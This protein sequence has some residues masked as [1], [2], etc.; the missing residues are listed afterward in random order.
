MG[1][2]TMTAE[3]GISAETKANF[4][5]LPGIWL[6][7]SEQPK[8]RKG[9]S[10]EV[11]QK[12]CQDS[13]EDVINIL[14]EEDGEV[15]EKM[16]NAEAVINM[17]TE[18]TKAQVKWVLPSEKTDELTDEVWVT[19]QLINNEQETKTY[20]KPTG[21]MWTLGNWKKI[22]LHANDDSQPWG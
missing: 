1:T 5:A 2:T 15:N 16:T 17:M 12:A 21:W 20:N 7:V 8:G 18:Q 6:E 19:A 9:P 22:Q 3:V 10:F 11:V 13:S 14:K 4:V